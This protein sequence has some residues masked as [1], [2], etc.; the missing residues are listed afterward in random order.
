MLENL[1][2]YEAK[3]ERCID[4]DTLVLSLDRGFDDWSVKTVRLARIDAPEVRGKEREFGKIAKEYVIERIG[5][6]DRL[7]AKSIELDGF[8]RAIAEVYLEEKGR[9]RNLSDELVLHN[10]AIYKKY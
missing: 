7:M 3:L 9:W 6:C 1:Y 10:F 5:N 4:G 8:G 2:Y